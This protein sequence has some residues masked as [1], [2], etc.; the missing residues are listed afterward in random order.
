MGCSYFDI[1]RD[2]RAVYCYRYSGT[3]LSGRVKW[4]LS[5]GFPL[6]PTWIS[7]FFLPNYIYIHWSIRSSSDNVFSM[8]A[9]LPP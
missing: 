7:T 3:P 5:I 2:P 4:L 9:S 6:A 8:K 1:L